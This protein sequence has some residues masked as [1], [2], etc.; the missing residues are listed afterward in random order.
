MKNKPKKKNNQN[1]NP[2]IPT[3]P[4]A[5]EKQRQQKSK[6]PCLICGG[7]HYT[8]YCPHHDEVGK[9]F[10]GNSQPVVLTQPFPQQQSLILQAPAPPVGGNPNHHHSEEAS[11]SVH[12]YMFN[13][14]DL[15]TRTIAYD[16]LIKPDKEKIPNGTT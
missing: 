11:S 10:K 4:P 8:R 5:I 15:T 3:Q 14:I 2:K 1:D 9:V 13:G 16:T 7:D 6:F 12:I